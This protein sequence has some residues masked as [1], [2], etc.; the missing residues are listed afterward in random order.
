[1]KCTT[2]VEIPTAIPAHIWWRNV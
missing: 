2:M 1:M